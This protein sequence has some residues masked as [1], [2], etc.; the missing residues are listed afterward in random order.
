MSFTKR[1]AKIYEHLK[2]SI[3]EIRNVPIMKIKRVTY[4]FLRRLVNKVTLTHC[5]ILTKRRKPTRSHNK[6]AGDLEKT[7]LY[8]KDLSSILISGLN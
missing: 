4:F 5:K 7:G 3:H 2:N 8:K 6:I 1:S